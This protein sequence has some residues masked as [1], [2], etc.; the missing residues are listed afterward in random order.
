[1]GKLSVPL[2]LITGLIVIFIGFYSHL[3]TPQIILVVL[4]FQAINMMYG[5]VKWFEMP[6]HSDYES[7]Y[8]G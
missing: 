2:K 8:T 1:M 4:V 3:D 7:E 5:V 6:E